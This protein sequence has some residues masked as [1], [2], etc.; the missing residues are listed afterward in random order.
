VSLCVKLNVRGIKELEKHIL[1]IENLKKYFPIQKGLFKRTIGYI[2]AVDG[3][4]L[5]VPENHVIGIVGES[6]CGKSTLARTILRFYQPDAG[7]IIFEGEDITNLSESQLKPYRKKMQIIFQDEYSSLNPKLTIKSTLLDGVRQTKIPKGQRTQRI[8]ELLEMVGLDKD[9]AKKYPHEF[10]GGQRQ[11][12]GIARAISVNPK[13]IICDE[14]VS[15]LDVS[16]QAQII[17][18]LMD[19][20]Q[21][22]GLSLIF[23]SHDLNLVGYFCDFVYVMYMGKIVEYAPTNKLF[24]NPYHPYTKLL[25]DSIPGKTKRKIKLRSHTK[26]L[27]PS[28]CSFSNRCPFLSEKCENNIELKEIEKGHGV[29]CVLIN[30][31]F[32]L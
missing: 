23:I 7:K 6:G 27:P 24:E 5:I 10:S 20:K 14:P 32:I 29:R 18:L 11:R 4:D 17:N 3:V 31:E 25:L 2:K 26:F 30:S 8:F 28:G 15:A 12:I 13:L 22:M 19:L 21:K 9:S 16:V 1:R